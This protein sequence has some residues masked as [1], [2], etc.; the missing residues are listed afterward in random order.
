MMDFLARVAH[1][2]ASPSVLADLAKIYIGIFCV[3]FL[4]NKIQKVPSKG[5]RGL[6]FSCLLVPAMFVYLWAGATFSRVTTWSSGQTLTASA[7]NA[8][9]QNVLNNFTF[10]GLDDYS[11]NNTEMRTVTDPYPGSAESLATSGQGELE[12]LRY[13]ILEIKK[14]IQA[15]N[16]T[17]WYQDAPTSGVFSIYTTSANATSMGITTA[18]VSSMTVTSYLGFPSSSNLTHVK[19]TLSGDVTVSGGTDYEMLNAWT[20]TYDTL[21][22][23]GASTFTAANSGKYHVCAN[24]IFRDSAGDVTQALS[25]IYINGAFDTTLFIMGSSAGDVELWSGNG[26][27]TVSLSANDSLTVRAF[28]TGGSGTLTIE[29]S[30]AVG[31]EPPSKT[32][33]TIDRIF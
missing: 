24:L 6:L 7:L 21:S 27:A 2:L 9:F 15:S 22:E 33:L 19:S 18:T 3:F 4:V 20:D 13:Q 31:T 16:V 11:A 32:V 26:C 12:R 29:N 30:V 14:S 5:M 23:M 28:G 25:A 8:E 17:Y 1:N 10:A